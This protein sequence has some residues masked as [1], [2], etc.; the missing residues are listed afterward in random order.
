MCGNVYVVEVGD[1]EGKREREGEDRTTLNFCPTKWPFHQQLNING[2]VRAAVWHSNETLPVV[3]F[4]RPV[5]IYEVMG[6]GENGSATRIR[7]YR[8]LF[9]L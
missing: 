1:E 4:C 2:A 7:A 8:I 9:A 5:P 3:L 6:P